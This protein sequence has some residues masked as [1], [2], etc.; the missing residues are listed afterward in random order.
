M[1]QGLI[2]EG[3]VDAE[4]I[5]GLQYEQPLNDPEVEPTWVAALPLN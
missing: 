5:A 4:A 3:T 2:D 1:I